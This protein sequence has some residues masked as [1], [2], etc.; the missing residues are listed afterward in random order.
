MAITVKEFLQK[1]SKDIAVP[2]SIEMSI[3]PA[4]KEFS[5]ICHQVSIESFNHLQDLGIIHSK[6]DEQKVRQA[7]IEDDDKCLQTAQ[8]L[9]E[10]RMDDPRFNQ[11]RAPNLI[12]RR[13][14]LR[15]IY[16]GLRKTHNFSLAVLLSESYSRKVEWDSIIPMH[17]RGWMARLDNS[18]IKPLFVDIGKTND[19]EVNNDSIL[20]LYPQQKMLHARHIRIHRGGKIKSPYIMIICQSIQG[21]IP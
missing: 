9:F 17:V 19:I 3:D 18:W 11:K 15:L 21:D 20:N 12:K 16:E 13:S 7:L 14:G 4:V 5:D 8:R 6:L 2:K 10:N 1:K